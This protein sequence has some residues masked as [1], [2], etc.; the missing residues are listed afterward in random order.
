MQNV[1]VTVDFASKAAAVSK[2]TIRRWAKIDLIPHRRT[3]SGGLRV[4]RRAL[5]KESMFSRK[6]DTI[7]AGIY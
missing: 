5:T 6:V 3:A 4:D 7:L 1:W 2:S